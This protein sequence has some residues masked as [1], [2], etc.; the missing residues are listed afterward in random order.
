MRSDVSFFTNHIRRIVPNFT[1]VKPLADL[2][3][4]RGYHTSRYSVRGVGVVLWIKSFHVICVVAWFAGI[5]YLPRLFVYHAEARDEISLSRFIVMER[6]L[7]RGIM[8]PAGILATALGVWLVWLSPDAFLKAGWFHIKLTAVIFL[9]AY[10]FY[11][12]H[13]RKQFAREENKH[14]PTFYRWLN[15]IPVLFLVISVVMVI[16]KPQWF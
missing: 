2:S 10:H 8:T 9:W 1:G 4:E 11:C 6:R 5:F 14:G 15:E 3:N 12:D 7:Y 13:L 16:V